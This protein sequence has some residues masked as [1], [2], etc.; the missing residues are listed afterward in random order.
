M[1]FVM[2]KAGQ[3]TKLLRAKIY[4]QDPFVAAREESVGIEEITMPSPEPVLGS[5]PSTSRVVVVDYN[6][7][8]DVV[9]EPA[10]PLASGAGFNTGRTNELE[11]LKFHQVNAWAV[12]NRTLQLL[13]GERVLGR[14][15]PWAFSGG[16][17][18][19]IPHAGY[20]ENAYYDRSTGALHFFYFEGKH[21]SPVFTC[22]SHDIITHEL[23]H[24]VLD[25]LKPY[26][27]EISSPATAGFHEFFGDAVA[28]ATKLTHKSIAALVAGR[29]DAVNSTSL[30]TNL[31][32]GF[33]A[34]LADE[35]GSLAD[36]YLRSAA[37]QKK[38]KHVK[39]VYEEHKYSEVL[40]GAYYSFLKTAYATRLKAAINDPDRPKDTDKQRRV[41]ALISAAGVTARMLIRAVDYCPPVDIQFLDF[42]RAAIRSDQMA[43]PLDVGNHRRD[44]INVFVDRGIAKSE[45]ELMP[46]LELRN[47]DLRDLDVE[48]LSSSKTDAYDFVNANRHA[49]GIPA[50]ANLEVINV[51]RTN[52]VSS[53][54]YR[55]PREIIVEFVWAEDVKLTGDG[56]GKLHG[57]T[58]PLWCGGTLVFSRDG[59]I[60]HYVL[61]RDTPQRRGEL[62]KYIRHLVATKAISMASGERGFGSADRG[63]SVVGHL[64]G[65]QLR[66]NR[67]SAFRHAGRSSE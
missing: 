12:V 17:L 48:R 60:L 29:Q 49:L 15:V 34:G 46:E 58:V 33:G 2:K 20:W 64:D 44:L 50:P 18:T 32:A 25:G 22:L 42:A 11:N 3:S 61:K 19:I 16:R 8:L 1:T 6:A 54:G 23:G 43:Y 41:R 9:F 14:R 7:D 53:S 45:A 27:N 5:G 13:E 35:Y 40:T 21:G 52:K 67:S 59:N 10:A 24:A 39:N 31:A 36:A 65:R 56:F 51:Y 63:G 26:Y 55:P 57:S 37:N 30:I 38:M 4:L 47:N 62:R 66:L 28:I